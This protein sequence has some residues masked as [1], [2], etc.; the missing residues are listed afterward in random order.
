MH[1]TPLIKAIQ[2][3]V[4]KLSNEPSCKF[5]LHKKIL[6]SNCCLLYYRRK[7]YRLLDCKAKK[8]EFERYIQNP[9]QWGHSHRGFCRKNSFL[10]FETLN[11]TCQRAQNLNFE[12]NFRFKKVFLVRKNYFRFLHFSLNWNRSSEISLEAQ[13]VNFK[14]TS[15]LRGYF[16]F[17]NFQN[18]V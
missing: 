3:E 2:L 14:G 18:F 8:H 1:L 4:S 15:G 9:I 11:Y 10:S 5:F 6:Q 13:I 12:W 16:R 7:C 17:H